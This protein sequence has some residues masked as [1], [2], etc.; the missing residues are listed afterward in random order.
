MKP[1]VF[2]SQQAP[3]EVASTQ[4]AAMTKTRRMCLFLDVEMMVQEGYRLVETMSEHILSPDWISNKCIICAYDMDT[5]VFVYANQG[6]AFAR[7]KFDEQNAENEQFW[8][9]FAPRRGEPQLETIYGKHLINQWPRDR[10]VHQLHGLGTIYPSEPA[11][12]AAGTQEDSWSLSSA[13]D[14]EPQ[15]GGTEV[16]RDRV[17]LEGVG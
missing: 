5:N 17:H 7:S 9:T 11:V 14:V 8:K 1:Y 13:R 15:Q 4:D 6:Y 3:W 12:L 2:M 10:E 16:L